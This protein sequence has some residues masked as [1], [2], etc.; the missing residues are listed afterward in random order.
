MVSLDALFEEI[1]EAQDVIGNIKDRLTISSACSL[2]QPYHIKLDQLREG[3]KQLTIKSELLEE[4]LVPLMKIELE[5]DLFGV[6]DLYDENK[7]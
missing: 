1:E 4:E 3:S 6:T 2:I 5:E 7:L